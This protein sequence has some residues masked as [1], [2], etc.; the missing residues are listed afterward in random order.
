M[1]K[2]EQQWCWCLVGNIVKAHKF[3]ENHEIRYGTKHFSS[4]TK[5]YINLVFKGMGN[6]SVL[7]IGKPRH[8]WKCIE[9]VISRKYIENFRLQKVFKPVVLQRMAESKYN[10][11]GKEDLNRDIIIK[12]AE[13]FNMEIE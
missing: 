8:S 4:G 3:G 10:W 11:W 13:R 12:C 2:N 6:E 1:N 7:V 9:I 5:V